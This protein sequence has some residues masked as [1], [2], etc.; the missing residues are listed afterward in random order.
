M[1]SEISEDVGE[2]VIEILKKLNLEIEKLVKRI[3]N[4]KKLPCPLR[5]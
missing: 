2:E 5:D 4:E 3:Y 1:E